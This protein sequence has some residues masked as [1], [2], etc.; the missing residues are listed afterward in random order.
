VSDT[1]QTTGSGEARSDEGAPR[2]GGLG[3]I[4]LTV[5]LDLV[6]FS[7]IFPL[8]PEMLEY[9]VSLEGADSL[10]GQLVATLAELAP[11]GEQQA[12][13]TVVLFGGL[14]GS[15]YSL[16]TFVAAPLWGSLSDRI[17]RRRV[18]L[19]T[20]SAT[21]L[22]YV[23][24]FFAG[25]FVVLVIA[26]IIGG[27]ASGNLSV[28]TAAVSDV[29][30]AKD[31]AKGMGMLG[32][33]F[34]VG[35]IIG[36]TMGAVL[37]LARVDQWFSALPGVNPFSGAALG[38]LILATINVVWIWRRF[39]E[40]LKPSHSAARPINPLRLFAPTEF[41]GV[42]RTNLLYFIFI[43]AFAG[44][45]FTLTF[46]ARDRFNYTSLDNGLIFLFV[47]V[48]SVIVQGGLVRK[49]VPRIGERRAI[50]IGLVLI[51]PGLLLIGAAETTG[52]MY[53]GLV[54]IAFGSGIA[55][56]SLTSLVSLYAPN[57]RQGELL[58]SFRSLGSLARGVAPIGASVLYWQLGS[59]APY[60]VSAAAMAIPLALSFTL[61][62]H[63][64]SV[65][66]ERG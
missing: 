63:S 45:E 3:V 40:T 11:E 53:A 18:L 36:P 56:P 30:T 62:A 61:P 25:T 48:L 50:Q 31:R 27:A 14:V 26:R 23:V 47:G 22:S 35:F 49:L 43:S 64:A 66:Q 7:I 38:A 8:F 65:T 42:N 21:A 55:T 15:V 4:L 16:L 6:G 20:V 37:S 33:S 46:L 24:W 17:G 9:Y 10:V 13:Y 51:T 39:P 2:K 5:F 19:I 12:F 44:M 52:V 1:E 59:A 60:W 28:A 32:A 57:D 34:G 58:G 29:T 54:F 41:K